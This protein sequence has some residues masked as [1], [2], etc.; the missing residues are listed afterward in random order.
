VYLICTYVSYDAMCISRRNTLEFSN[1]DRSFTFREDMA[2]FVENIR[3]L[4]MG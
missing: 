3:G 1:L 2:T 4:Y